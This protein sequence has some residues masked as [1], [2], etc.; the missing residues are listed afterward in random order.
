MLREASEHR[1][2]KLV[3]M[4]DIKMDLILRLSHVLGN[5]IK[6]KTLMIPVI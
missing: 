1:P 3:D 2:N 6:K 4:E 5:I